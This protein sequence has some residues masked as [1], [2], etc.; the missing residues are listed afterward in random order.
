MN[1]KLLAG[2]AVVVAL[3]SAWLL[4][5][6]TQSSTEP[7]TVPATTVN[8][9]SGQQPMVEESMEPIVDMPDKVS[10]ETSVEICAEGEECETVS[11]EDVV[12]NEEGEIV[13]TSV[14]VVPN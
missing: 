11:A 4:L 13:E 8:T 7:A 6:V 2:L 12:S 3:L 9:P 10:V 5:A 14:E 1:T